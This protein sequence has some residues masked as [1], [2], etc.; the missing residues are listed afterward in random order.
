MHNNVYTQQAAAG[1]A[2]GLQLLQSP[3]EPLPAAMREP[4]LVLRE[5]R[6]LCSGPTLGLAPRLAGVSTMYMGGLLAKEEYVAWYCCCCC[7]DC[8]MAPGAAPG[9]E[10]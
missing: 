7:A 1:A 9:A 10:L 4:K 8:C 5:E 2:P 3:T 6:C